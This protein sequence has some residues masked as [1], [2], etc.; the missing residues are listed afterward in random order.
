M[1]LSIS[2][3]GCPDWRFTRIVSEFNRMGIEGI[4]VR[5][6]EGEMD[7]AKIPW[8]S[9]ENW[10]ITRAMLEEN[11]LRIVGLGT[12]VAFHDADLFDDN[13]R[14]GKEAIDLCRRIGIPAIRVFGDRITAEDDPTVIIDRAAKGLK[15][16]CRYA[17]PDGV[18]IN[19][20]TH[21]NFNTIE[22]IGALL[23]AMK[24]EPAFGILWDIQHSDRAYRDDYLP[25]YELIRPYIRH[26]HVKDYI[27]KEG[28]AFELCLVGEGDIPI[29]PII[30]RL[31][32]DGYQGYFSLEW[33]KKWHPELPEADI[34]FPGF[35]RYMKNL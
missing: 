26:V 35:V 3:L 1:K 15:Q 8:F 16:L 14:Q 23:D 33:E 20:E 22:V 28:D 30:A 32:A 11:N 18:R 5:G 7:P 21:G 31:L 12:S 4:E 27:R 10:P 13:I 17:G 24:D 29:K 25:F 34:A 19:L 9:E 2:T 6:I